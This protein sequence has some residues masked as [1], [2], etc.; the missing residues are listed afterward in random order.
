M[1]K[2]IIPK[3]YKSYLS[4]YETQ[5]AIEFIKDTFEN[6][7]KSSLNLKR[8]SAPLFLN[9]STGLNDNLNGVE[10]PVC[11][12]IKETNNYAEIET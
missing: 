7:L 6:F 8:I 3:N 10:K 2:I 9:P 11:F 5:I 4:L 12:K 1:S